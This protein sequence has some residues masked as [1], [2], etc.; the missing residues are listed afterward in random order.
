MTKKRYLTIPQI[1]KETG[2]SQQTIQRWID[3]NFLPARRRVSGNRTSVTVEHK[4]VEAMKKL[5]EAFEYLDRYWSGK[6]TP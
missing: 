5:V 6:E 4:A 2:W 3:G 1:A